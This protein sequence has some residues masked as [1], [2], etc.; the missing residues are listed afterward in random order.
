MRCV[1]CGHE[2]KDGAKFCTGCGAALPAESESSPAAAAAPSRGPHPLAI[3]AAVVLVG[4]IALGVMYAQGTGPFSAPSPQA[5][6]QQDP[7]TSVEPEEPQAQVS[8][9]ASEPEPE[10]EPEY[11]TVS[12]YQLVH[13]CMTWDEA[14]RY[15]EERGGHL[16]TLSSADELNEVL[17]QLPAE[18]LVSCWLG[19]YRTSGGGW[20]WVD[21]SEFSYAA[22][23]SGEPNNEDGTE[24]YVTLLKVNGSWAMYDVPGDVSSYYN[25]AKIGFVMETEEQVAL[26]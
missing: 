15:C 9:P 4:G 11:V 8:V 25:N 17:A 18:G 13:Q 24:N 12:H 26:S 2:N 16:A 7:M 10:P 19:G 6:S 5:A 3:V 22:W 23:A 14:R 20:A 1:S 21:G